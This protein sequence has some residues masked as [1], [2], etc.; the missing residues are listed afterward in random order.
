M[1]FISVLGPPPCLG[2]RKHFSFPTVSL[3]FYCLSL[4]VC[5]IYTHTHTFATQC[6]KK[7]NI[8]FLVRRFKWRQVGVAAS[9]REERQPWVALHNADTGT[10]RPQAL[11]QLPLAELCVSK[12]SGRLQTPAT[13]PSHFLFGLHPSVKIIFSYK[14]HLIDELHLLLILLEH[15]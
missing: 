3:C 14:K 9:G 1:F 7:M 4:F 5:I 6:G 11:H 15:T 12:H 10:V 8:K 13:L 2:S